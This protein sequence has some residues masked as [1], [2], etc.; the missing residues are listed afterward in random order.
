MNVQ[1]LKL[2]RG[3]LIEVKGTSLKL[4][5]PSTLQVIQGNA[6]LQAA[7]MRA[8]HKTDSAYPIDRAT[9][10]AVVQQEIDQL[11]IAENRILCSIDEEEMEGTSFT[12]HVGLTNQIMVLKEVL[13]KITVL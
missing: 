1:Q 12:D 4:V 13:K 5:A 10:C 3:D 7:P 2:K 6:A 8:R 11:E 9:V